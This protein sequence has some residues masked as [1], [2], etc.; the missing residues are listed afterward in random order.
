ME[1]FD[2]A[3]SGTKHLAEN[4]IETV[5]E[6]LDFVADCGRE[7]GGG[8]VRHTTPTLGVHVMATNQP[9]AFPFLHPSPILLIFFI[10]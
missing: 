3:A 6:C 8:E 7:Q 5:A 9:L 4:Y 10:F 1:L 2:E